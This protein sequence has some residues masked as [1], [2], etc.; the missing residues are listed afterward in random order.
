MHQVMKKWTDTDALLAVE[1]GI[2]GPIWT[3]G[4]VQNEFISS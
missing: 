3:F 4:E 1:V 2:S